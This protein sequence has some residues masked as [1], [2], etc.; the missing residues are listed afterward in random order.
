MVIDVADGSALAIHSFGLGANNKDVWL[1][2]APWNGYC[3]WHIETGYFV[4]G[5]TGNYR[6]EAFQERNR[7]KWLLGR[8]SRR[9]RRTLLLETSALTMHQSISAMK[10]GNR[11][12]SN[13]LR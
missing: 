12:K 11:K 2:V 7:C 4:L 13:S 9:L 10:C 5:T 8:S 1:L 6:L 3:S